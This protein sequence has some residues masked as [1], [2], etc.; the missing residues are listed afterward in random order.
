MPG[1][2]LLPYKNEEVRTVGEMYQIAEVGFSTAD[3]DP[4]SITFDGSGTLSV[5]FRDWRERTVRLK[6][7]E[8]V[9]FRW[10]ECDMHAGERD[11]VTYEIANSLWLGRLKE[12]NAAGEGHLHYKLCFNASGNLDVLFKGLESSVGE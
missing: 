11:D 12:R 2:R 5:E 4:P 9:G 3:A 1:V 8:V 7:E 6:F 10:D